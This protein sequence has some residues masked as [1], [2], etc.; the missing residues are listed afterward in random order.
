MPVTPKIQPAFFEKLIRGEFKTNPHHDLAIKIVKVK[1]KQV[2]LSIEV[3]DQRDGPLLQ[4]AQVT[5]QQDDTVT[6]Q[7]V[8]NCFNI[9]QSHS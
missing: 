4:L 7:G 5:V 9:T 1:G 6:L 2:T 3:I 8:G